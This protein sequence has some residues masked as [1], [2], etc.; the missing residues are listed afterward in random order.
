MSAA[1]IPPAGT[2]A[3]TF[4][5]PVDF[6]AGKVD[7]FQVGAEGDDGFADS[8]GRD[9]A[10]EAKELGFSAEENFGHRKPITAARGSAIMLA[11]MIVVRNFM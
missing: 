7:P 3:A 9:A 11:T 10:E 5:V 4:A 6:A 8:T 2:T 1:L